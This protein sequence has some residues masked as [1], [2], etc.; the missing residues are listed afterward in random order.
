MRLI[1]FEHACVRLESGRGVLVIDPG[2]FSDTAALDGADAI[3]ITHEHADHLNGGAI[4]AAVA[5]RPDVRV[6]THVDVAPNLAEVAGTVVSVAPG[7]AFEAA[8]FRVQAFGG[9]HAEIHPDVPRIANLGY[10]IDGLIYHPG[11]SLQ[12]PDGSTVDTL[13][14]PVSGP[15][16]KTA[17]AID[18]VRAVAPRQAVAIHEGL[19]N[20]VG[21][22]LVDGLFGRLSRTEF[23]RLPARGELIVG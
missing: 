12:V 1:K 17:E 21:L 13:L 8:G 10:L 11:D 3:L 16:L 4:V 7:D 5:S 23:Q 14:V 9:V 20:D 6:Y 19:Y 2:V 18:F 22:G 15:W